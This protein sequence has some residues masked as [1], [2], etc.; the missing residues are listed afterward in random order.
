MPS[1]LWW[2]QNFPG[3]DNGLTDDAGAPILNWWPYVY[4]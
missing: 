1:F 3:L 2:R 4:Y